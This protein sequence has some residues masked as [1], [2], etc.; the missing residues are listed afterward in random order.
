MKGIE[1]ARNAIFLK[2]L[3]CLNGIFPIVIY[4]KTKFLPKLGYFCILAT[5][6]F[7]CTDGR[8]GAAAAPGARLHP[9]VSVPSPQP[10]PDTRHHDR[11]GHRPGPLQGIHPGLYYDPS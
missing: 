4:L 11:S 8:G 1:I 7:M 3:I 5:Q 10:A 2:L 9:A 6:I